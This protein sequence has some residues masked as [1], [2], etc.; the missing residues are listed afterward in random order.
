MKLTELLVNQRIT[1]QLLFGEQKI[2]F[3]SDVIECDSAAAYT[4]PYIHSGSA[5]DLNITGDK[6][7]SCNVFA[8]EPITKQRISWKGVELTTINRNQSVVYCIKARGFNNIANP[9]DRRLHDRVVVNVSATALDVQNDI[10]ESIIIKDI[11]DS[12]IS[13]Y[14]SGIFAANSQQLRVTFTDK[15]DDRIFDIKMD[16]VIT[17]NSNENARILYGCRVMGENKDYRIYE[18]LKRLRSKAANKANVA[19]SAEQNT[20]NT[21]DNATQNAENAADNTEQNAEEN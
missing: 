14:A 1:V 11:S 17:R 20:D 16:C 6:G 12:G 15:I 19:D 13:F 3:F 8:D 2:E 9:D 18:L 5:L 21:A 10:Q 7:V 4:T